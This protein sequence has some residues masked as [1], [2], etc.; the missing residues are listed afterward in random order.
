MD[1]FEDWP[2]YEP[3]RWPLY[4]P[5]T[6]VDVMTD[7]W[8]M[9][10]PEPDGSEPDPWEDRYPDA[11]VREM[12]DPFT[13]SE[14]YSSEPPLYSSEPPLSDREEDGLRCQNHRQRSSMS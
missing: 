10:E 2:L 8:L 5:E 13:Q 11:L 1:H 3:Q 9:D 7:P 12:E 4:E 6:L 14:P